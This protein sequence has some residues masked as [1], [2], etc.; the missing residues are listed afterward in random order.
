VAERTTTSDWPVADRLDVLAREGASGGLEIDGSPGGTIY[1][2]GGYIT[3]AASPAVPDLAARLIGSRRVSG[4]QWSQ[5]MGESHPY[6][7]VGALLVERDFITKGELQF[8]LRSV[9]LDTIMALM[10]P[11]GRRAILAGIRFTPLAWHWAGSFLR[12]EAASVRAEVE[13]RTGR[14]ARHELPVEARPRLSDLRS[15]GAVVTR[16]QWVL[17]GMIDGVA[18]IR[19]LAWENGFALHDTI[20]WVAELADAGLCTWRV[21]DDPGRAVP[22]G[23]PAWN[24]PA[25][26]LTPALPRRRRGAT[27]APPDDAA[28]LPQRPKKAPLPLPPPP[29]QDLLHQL[30]DGLRR[31]RLDPALRHRSQE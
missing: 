9:V 27:F 11:S 10:A 30:L 14:L 21:L 17:T 23:I 12:L 18:T 15:A 16:E 8:V 13:R 25:A 3:F 4:E 24:R 19:D 5:L 29:S 26:D 31:L 22:G 28:G 1:L 20:E 6:S 2:E 7:G